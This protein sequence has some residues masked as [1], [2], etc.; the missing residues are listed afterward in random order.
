MVLRAPAGAQRARHVQRALA[1]LS[2]TSIL[3]AIN[4]A[5]RQTQ[6]SKRALQQR[7]RGDTADPDAGYETDTSRAQSELRVPPRAPAGNVHR[8]TRPS[9]RF[10]AV[11]GARVVQDPRNA[12]ART[13]YDAM[14]AYTDDDA[15]AASSVSSAS[16]PRSVAS[17]GTRPRVAPIRVPNPR[18]ASMP[19]ASAAAAYSVLG[20]DGDGQIGVDDY[21]LPVIRSTVR[22]GASASQPPSPPH[23]PPPP[24]PP[25][26]QQQL[27]APPGRDGAARAPASVYDNPVRGDGV[28]ELRARNSDQDS[29]DDDDDGDDD[30]KE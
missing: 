16:R 1:I 19:L 2:Q 10:G 8:R 13:A 22:M 15:G 30:E 18:S 6:R 3:A 17:V 9:R 28:D 25:R 24:I 5:A 23:D 26:P 20:D 12:M 7:G 21:G 11:R 29:G 14:A 4:Q 27:L